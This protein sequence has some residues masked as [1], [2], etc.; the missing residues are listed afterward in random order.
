MS[1]LPF[2]VQA[3]VYDV[4]G[5]NI[6]AMSIRQYG[7]WRDA[8]RTAA[9]AIAG[10]SLVYAQQQQRTGRGG[11]QRGPTN[12]EDRQRWRPNSEELLAALKIAHGR[13]LSRPSL[14]SP[15]SLCYS[16]RAG[17]SPRWPLGRIAQLVEQLTLNQRVPGSS[18]GAPT[19]NLQK[20]RTSGLEQV[21]ACLRP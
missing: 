21:I 14:D 19:K 6:R 18:P 15:G 12:T 4:Y 3:S 11:A 5:R 10:T 1:R 9:L 20:S 17:R 16:T 2:G 8:Y 13:G 7:P